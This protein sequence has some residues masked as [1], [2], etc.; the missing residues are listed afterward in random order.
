MKSTHR[1]GILPVA[2]VMV[3]AGVLLDDSLRAQQEQKKPSIRVDV[4]LVSILASVIDTNGRPVPDLRQDAFQLKEEGVPQKIE[5][6]E[7][8]TNRPLDLALMIDSSMSTF[9]DLKFEAEAAAHFIK[10]VVRPADT[11]SVF[12]FSDSVIQLSEFLDDVPRLQAAAERISP[13]AGTAMYDAV[14]LGS[15]ALRKLPQERRRAFRSLTTRAARQSAPA[16]CFIRSS[17]VR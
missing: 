13:G 3:C 5:R 11:L 12:E 16:R 17:F 6:F 14:V 15:N 4:N 7:A 1:L 2:A 8:Q 10:Q 9:K